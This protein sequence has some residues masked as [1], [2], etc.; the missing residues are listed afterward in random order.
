M[1]DAQST[2]QQLRTRVRILTRALLFYAK[3]THYHGLDNWEG[4]T[5]DDNW[6]C[7]PGDELPTPAQ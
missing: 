3:G 1:T 4:P 6:M 2:E 5:G 7:P